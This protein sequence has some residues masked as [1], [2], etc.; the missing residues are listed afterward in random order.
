MG[1][2]VTRQEHNCDFDTMFLQNI[3]GIL[4]VHFYVYDSKAF[5]LSRLRAA[6]ISAVQR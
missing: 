5:G 1:H 3:L 6:E 4:S 2:G